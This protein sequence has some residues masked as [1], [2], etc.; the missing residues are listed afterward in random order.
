MYSRMN[1]FEKTVNCF[2]NLPLDYKVFES[3]F[4]KPM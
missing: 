2:K 3:I 1:E 4:C